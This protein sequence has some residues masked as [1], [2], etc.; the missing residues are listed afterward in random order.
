MSRAPAAVSDWQQQ[1]AGL[2]RSTRD[3][4]LA[5]FYQSNWPAA[6]T[7]LED[8]PLIALDIETTGLDAR[9]HAIV[10]IGMLPFTLRRADCSRAWY[11]VVRPHGRL[12][13]ES[14][15]FHRIT[16]SEIRQAPRFVAVL[17]QLLEQLAGK[18][19]VAH[20]RHIERS[21]I[22]EAVRHE[23][24]EGLLFPMIDTM[25]LEARL[26]P[27]RQ[28][29]WL[30]RVLGRQP[31]SIRLADSRTRYGLPLYQ[32]HHALTDALATAE[33]FQAQVATHFS[34]QQRLGDLW[35]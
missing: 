22:D 33:L 8:V 17:E 15:A 19:V 18:V 4:R 20:Y 27:Q 6:D 9:R 10:S 5:R 11:Q 30:L 12:V 31:I 16:H 1:M 2:A 7:P 34:S 24:Q 32:A 29:G 28:P 25:E 26:H 21:F 23:L 13:E 14:V 3:P 35:C